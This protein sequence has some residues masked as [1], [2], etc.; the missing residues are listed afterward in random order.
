MSIHRMS[1]RPP[2]LAGLIRRLSV[3]IILGWLGMI[4]IVTFAVPSLEQV[5]RESSVSLVPQAAPSFRA[6]QRMGEVFGESNSDSVA[7]VVLEGNNPWTMTRTPTTTRWFGS[8]EPTP[9]TCST[10]RTTG[11][12]R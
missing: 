11:A 2:L 5:G 1:G 4:A 9:P 12:T 10:F 8:W 6:M 7:M 3:P